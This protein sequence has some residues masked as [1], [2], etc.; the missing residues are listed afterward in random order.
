MASLA[1][2]LTSLA[3]TVPKSSGVQP[4]G[5][6]AP[7]S[8]YWRK[9]GWDGMVGQLFFFCPYLQNYFI[10]FHNCL[11]S[12]L[13]MFFHIFWNILRKKSE[14][15]LFQ[16]ISPKST[17]PFF[18]KMFTRIFQ[19][20]RKLLDIFFSLFLVPLVEVQRHILEYSKKNKSEIF[21]IKKFRN[22]W[23][24]G[25]KKLWKNFLFGNISKTTQYFFLVIFGP[26]RRLFRTSFGTFQKNKSEFFPIKKISQLFFFEKILVEKIF[27]RISLIK[28][29]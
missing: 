20:S 8:L 19:I 4:R 10:L 3:R 29:L 25:K 5:T 23:F 26:L 15:S 9:V 18:A 12:Y 14:C 16:K 27:Q 2:A 17:P 28:F 24:S 7:A 13:I 1:R 6:R 11:R 21:P 22:F